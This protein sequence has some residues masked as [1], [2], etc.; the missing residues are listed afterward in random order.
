[1]RWMG[2]TRLVAS[3]CLA[4]CLALFSRP[5]RAYPWM[6]RHGYNNCATCHA[7]PSGA[8]LLTKYGR[9]QSAL[10]LSSRYGSGESE[11]E[12][13]RFSEALFG[14]VE[15]PDALLVGGWIRNGYLW[16]TVDGRLV[17]RRF[18]QMRADL[19]A[20][21]TVGSFR[22]NASAGYA[23]PDAGVLT[24][25][26]WLTSNGSGAHLVSREHWLGWD[27][28]DAVLVRAGRLNLPFGLRNIE[29]TSWAR[30][31]TR[32]DINQ[33]QQHGAA[34]S[35]ND[36]HVRAEAMAIAGNF[37]V[38]PD[39]YR[40]RGLAGYAEWSFAQ[41]QAVGASTLVSHASTAL[42]T[43]R[44]LLRQA[45]GA[46]AR[47]SWSRL[48]VLTEADLLLASFER[49][50]TRA[51]F[52]GLLQGDYEFV[53][54][55]HGIATLEGL[56]RP[57]AAAEWGLGT[58]VSAAWFFLPHFDVRADVVRRAGLAAPASMTYLIQLQGYL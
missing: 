50:P 43:R 18:L 58:W 35:F 19:A 13:G 29:H 20:Q 30:A 12:P 7:D 55:V 23:A 40:E 32:T 14:V 10:L 46:F 5:A 51:G 6:N 56:R 27:A 21:V 54:G 36:E 16:N 31:E 34:V 9:A 3:V 24:Q 42:G 37:Q 38:R 1:M 57:Q 53:Q 17:D 39:S 48:A 41:G 28:S 2:I 45:H 49:E 15:L 47:L 52:V 11:E 8:G 4:L 44:E 25:E 26:A 22:A 33:S